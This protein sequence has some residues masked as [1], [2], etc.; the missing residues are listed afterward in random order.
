[1]YGVLFHEFHYRIHAILLDLANSHSPLVAA[2]LPL[3][4]ATPVHHHF[5]FWQD[6]GGIFPS[7]AAP[8]SSRPPLL[9]SRGHFWRQPFRRWTARDPPVP[10]SPTATK[11]R[12][13]RRRVGPHVIRT[14]TPAAVGPPVHRGGGSSSRVEVRIFFY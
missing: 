8:S 4:V 11:H 10:S 5:F 6:R 2:M 13:A 1:M 12:R 3:F 9:S 14:A 7:H